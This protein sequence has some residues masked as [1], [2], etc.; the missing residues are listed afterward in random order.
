MDEIFKDWLRSDVEI[1]V[2]HTSEGAPYLPM[3]PDKSISISHS[4]D[5]C[6]LA[7][8]PAGMS[9]G[10]DI[11]SE[12]EQLRRVAPRV[13]SLGELRLYDDGA[14]GLLKAWTLKEALYKAALTPGLDFARDIKIPREYGDV[15]AIVRGDV[16]EILISEEFALGMLP[17]HVNSRRFPRHWISAV[18]R[19]DFPSLCRMRK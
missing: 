2:A 3:L 12:R 15:Y 11:E 9:I 17:A 10:V 19:A 14:D 18:V 6:A 4:R 1:E 16:Y 8:A 13:L 5:L 7:I